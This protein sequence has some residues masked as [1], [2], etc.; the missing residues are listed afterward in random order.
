MIDARK[1]AKP[2]FDADGKG[3]FLFG[4]DNA[5]IAQGLRDFADRVA[6]G[7]ISM[8]SIQSGQIAGGDNW[9]SSALYFEFIEKGED[10]TTLVARGLTS[11]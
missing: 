10:L 11:G 5:T 2:K 7:D 4:S 8:I 9:L 1:F 6:R 3:Q